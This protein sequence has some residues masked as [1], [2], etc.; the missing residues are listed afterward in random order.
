MN[1]QLLEKFYRNECTPEEVKEVLKWFNKEN[2]EQTQVQD[3]QSIWE[4]ATEEKHDPEYAHDADKLYA[5]IKGQIT[6]T[7]SHNETTVR[8]LYPNAWRKYMRIA[9]ALLLPVIGISLLFNIYQQHQA[10][11]IVTVVSQPGVKKI[12]TL[13][14]GSVV[15]LHSGS[16]ISYPKRFGETREIILKGEA[17]FEVAKDKHHPFIVHTG[18]ISTQALGTSFNI[19]YEG[20]DSTISIAL[21]TGV[22]K[23]DKQQNASAQQLAILEPG[24]QLVYKKQEQT[25]NVA[26]FDQEKVLGWKEGLLY[27]KNASLEEVVEEL[28]RWYGVQIEVQGLQAKGKQSDWQYTGKYDSQSLDAVLQGISF[29]KKVSY[30]KAADGSIILSLN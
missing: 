6:A 21:A 18:K 19:S 16:S 17:F 5:S 11:E 20:K 3:M 24:Q 23:I 15:K 27:F 26:A 12:I 1:S 10:S 8:E 2:P 14:D 29:V 22:V 7:E 9:A 4:E 13:A 30:Q 28:E 25:F